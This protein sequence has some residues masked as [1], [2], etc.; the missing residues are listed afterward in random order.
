MRQM[1]TMNY[2]IGN[3]L[4]CRAFLN[5]G[6]EHTYLQAHLQNEAEVHCDFP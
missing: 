6:V 3:N 2:D 4:V 5:W 1:V